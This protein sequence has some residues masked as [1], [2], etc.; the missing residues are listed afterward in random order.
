VKLY[1]AGKMT[2]ISQFNFPAFH[3]AARLLRG[4]GYEVF[5]PAEHD[6]A[7]GFDSSQMTGFEVLDGP[8]TLREMLLADTSWICTHAEGIALI[9]GWE[10]SK[11]AVAELALARALGLWAGSI[12]EFLYDALLPADA[13]FRKQFCA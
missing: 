1:L 11:G 7:M 13:V 10:T 12:D 6:E 2:G 9:P 5:S 3:D 4:A 8:Y